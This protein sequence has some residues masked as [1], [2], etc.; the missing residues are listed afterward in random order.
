MV[1]GSERERERI[2]VLEYSVCVTGGRKSGKI[3]KIMERKNAM[4][5]GNVALLK[6]TSKF[7][8]P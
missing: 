1:R 4:S 7:L 8:Y 2:P 5:V 3:T 6:N